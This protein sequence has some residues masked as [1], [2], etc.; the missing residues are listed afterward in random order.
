MKEEVFVKNIVRFSM[1]ALVFV[2]SVAA[3]AVPLYPYYADTPPDFC[4][5]ISGDRACWIS[6]G[7]YI[8]CTAKGTQTCQ[9]SEIVGGKPVRCTSV[10]LSAGCQCDPATYKTTGY[11][12]YYK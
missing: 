6:T 1:V 3:Q 9:A 11:C 8:Q 2:V 5:P 10:Q 7:T 4:G 12:T